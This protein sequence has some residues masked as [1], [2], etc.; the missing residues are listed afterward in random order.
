VTAIAGRCGAGQPADGGIIAQRGHG[1]QG[2]VAGTLD[3]PFIVLFDEDGADEPD[4]GG[5]IVDK[6]CC[7]KRCADP[8]SKRK[9]ADDGAFP[10]SFGG[11]RRIAAIGATF[12]DLPKCKM[13]SM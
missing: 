7:T 11:C 3:R 10:P 6:P 12:E 9:M 8:L 2:Q 4:D 5:L 1:F 13:A